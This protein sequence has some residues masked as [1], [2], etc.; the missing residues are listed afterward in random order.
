VVVVVDLVEDLQRLVLPEM[1]VPEVE[2][3]V[4]FHLHLQGLQELEVLD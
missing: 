2:V 1:V 3:E 4:M